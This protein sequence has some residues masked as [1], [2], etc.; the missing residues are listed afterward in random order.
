MITQKN[1]IP[2]RG[3]P[4]FE[5]EGGGLRRLSV[6][7]ISVKKIFVDLSIFK[8]ASKVNFSKRRIEI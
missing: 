8:N 2:V 3:C 4:V 5:G 7:K 6:M 1:M